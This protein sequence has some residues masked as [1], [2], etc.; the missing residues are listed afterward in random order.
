MKG[1]CLI[2]NFKYIIFYY[3]DEFD[4]YFMIEYENL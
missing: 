2:N 3:S 4:I 1:F